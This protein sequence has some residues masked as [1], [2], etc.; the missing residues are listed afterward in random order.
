MWMQTEVES[1]LPNLNT[2]DEAPYDC[3]GASGW[4]GM[5]GGATLAE[6]TV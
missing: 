2:E 4:V 3:C 6:D 1:D 5:G